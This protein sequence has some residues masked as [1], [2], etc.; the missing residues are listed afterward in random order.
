MLAINPIARNVERDCDL[1]V[2]RWYAEDG[3]IGSSISQ[4]LGALRIIYKE[5]SKIQFLLQPSKTKTFLADAE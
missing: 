3:I 1:V 2:P 4:V 5:G